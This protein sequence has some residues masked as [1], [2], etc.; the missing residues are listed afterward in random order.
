MEALH[1]I[2][3]IRVYNKNSRDGEA[4]RNLDDGDAVIVDSLLANVERPEGFDG[5]WC[6]LVHYLN[7]CDPSASEVEK[8]RLEREWLGR[9][10][11]CITTSHYTRNCL[12]KAGVAPERV[13]VV[14]PG[15][16][17][18][19]RSFQKPSPQSVDTC[20][21]LTVASLLPG[22][23]LVESLEIL[24]T[25][26]PLSWTWDI[27]GEGSLNPA[28]T[29]FFIERLNA[30]PV[31][32]R[33]F[34]AGAVEEVHMPELYRS[35]DMLLVSSYFETLGMSIREAMAS[36]VPVIAF[37]VGGIAESLLGGGGI[38]VDPFHQDRMQEDVA[39]LIESTEER[40]TLGDKGLHASSTFPGWEESAR[41]FIKVIQNI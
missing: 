11:V 29:D 32:D 25:L 7:I 35:H 6:L 31:T 37:D 5:L 1:D 2:E 17:E 21:L 10:D 19:Y 8:R 22:K 23:G 4:L 41:T 28:F 20:R 9:Y 12:I 39:R 30:S 24:E 18:I 15:L 3:G 33:V 13:H 40:I 27:V 16:E 38:L 26:A 34:W 14:Y 36:G